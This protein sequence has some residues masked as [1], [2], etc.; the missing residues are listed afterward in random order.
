MAQSMYTCLLIHAALSQG[1]LKGTLNSI[2]T[3]R[4]CWLIALYGGKHPNPIAVS[5]PVLSQHCQGGIR[6]RDIPILAS[7]TKTDMQHLALAIDILDLRSNCAFQL[8]THAFQ[9]AQSTRI[10]Q[11]QADLITLALYARQDAL[12]F[13]YTQDDRQ[14]FSRVC[15]YIVPM[16]FGRRT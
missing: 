13:L 2:F 12:H 1:S 8:Q 6:Q 9:Q 5:L 3:H 7:F 16:S 15:S 10:D 14:F 4:S 11:G